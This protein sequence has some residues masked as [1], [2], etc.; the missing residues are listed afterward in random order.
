[1]ARSAVTTADRLELGLMD[2]AEQAALIAAGL[3]S[4][5][6]FPATALALLARGAPSTRLT[7]VPHAQTG[8]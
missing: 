5:L 6:I 3:I 4:V 2:G 8:R 7:A 1:M